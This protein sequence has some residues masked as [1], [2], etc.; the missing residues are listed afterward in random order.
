MPTPYLYMFIGRA[1]APYET[2]IPVSF[3][4]YTIPS[5]VAVRLIE[6]FTIVPSIDTI[7]HGHLPRGVEILNS[8]Q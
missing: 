7:I 4:S 8:P 1:C 5:T 2:P 3:Q 6:L